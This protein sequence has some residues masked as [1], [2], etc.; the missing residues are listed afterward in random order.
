MS[1]DSG[2]KEDKEVEFYVYVNGGLLFIRKDI[3]DKCSGYIPLI[4]AYL[5][6][7]L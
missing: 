4:E 6:I 1:A 7:H 2:K 5:G 3:W